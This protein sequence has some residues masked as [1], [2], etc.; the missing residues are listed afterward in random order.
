MAIWI[1]NTPLTDSL[2]KSESES[3]FFFFVTTIPFRGVVKCSVHS[4][5]I[6]KYQGLFSYSCHEKR[7]HQIQKTTS[8]SVHHLIIMSKISRL[9]VRMASNKDEG[10]SHEQCIGEGCLLYCVL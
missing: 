1:W 8:S 6:D 10:Q 9:Y 5:G 3:Y 4:A 2:H 7:N